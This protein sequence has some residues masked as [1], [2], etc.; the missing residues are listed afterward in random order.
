[1][2]FVRP[3]AALA[4][5]LATLPA[6]GAP[7][8]GREVP[9]ADALRRLAVWGRELAGAKGS[10]SRRAPPGASPGWRFSRSDIESWIE[11]QS[12]GNPERA[13]SKASNKGDQK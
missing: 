6:T 11:Q 12:A 1:M 5:P 2:A 10:V 4:V 8:R 13:A 9:A 7:P 3:A